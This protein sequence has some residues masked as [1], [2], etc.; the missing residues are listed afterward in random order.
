MTPLKR[1][2]KEAQTDKPKTLLSEPNLNLPETQT[3][4]T[5]L[6]R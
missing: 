4:E 3:L 2:A 1:F 6:S 5:E